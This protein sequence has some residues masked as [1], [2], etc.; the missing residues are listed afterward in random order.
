VTAHFVTQDPAKRSV[1]YI[2]FGDILNKWEMEACRRN[3]T[4]K[5]SSWREAMNIIWENHW[6]KREEEINEKYKAALPKFQK[7]DAK[8]KL[9]TFQNWSGKSI[10]QLA[11]EVDHFEAYEIFYSELSSFSHIDIH[12]ADQFLKVKADGPVWTQ[13]ADDHQVGDVFRYS[14]TF[15]TCFLDLMA[16]QF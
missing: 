2:K 5:K 16:D 8:G 13:R 4:S 12:L 1:Q 15:M 14:I 3:R 9:I 7:L 6:T 10:R 11:K